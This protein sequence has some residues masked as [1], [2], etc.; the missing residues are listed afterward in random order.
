MNCAMSRAKT[1]RQQSRD[2][3]FAL[4]GFDFKKSFAFGGAGGGAKMVRRTAPAPGP[5]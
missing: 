3:Q 5:V 1:R 4:P 2:G